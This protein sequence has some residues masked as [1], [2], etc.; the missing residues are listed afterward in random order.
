MRTN[1]LKHMRPQ[2]I[3]DAKKEKSIVYLPIGPLEWHGPALPFGVDP[4]IAELNAKIIADKVGGVV[5]PTLYCGTERERT[6]E[7]LDAMGFEDTDQYIVGQDFPGNTVK[8]LYSKEDIFANIVREYIRL[9]VMQKYKLIVI[10]NG[11]GADG[12]FATLDRLCKEFTNESDSTVMWCMSMPENF[13]PNF[14]GHANIS[15]TSMQMYICG[16]D[17]D[18]SQLPSK[19][20]KLKNCEWGINDLST[21][22][23]HPNADKTVIGDP[24]DATEEIGQRLIEE[25]IKKVIAEIESVYSKICDGFSGG[26]NG[27]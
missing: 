26:I 15:E 16:E 12:Q 9:L 11:H 7:I 25:G 10:V 13:D 17:V 21:Y 8:S 1:E 22:M 20:V 14:M 4:Q 6:P 19:D 23:L 24:R 2:E 27:K 5:M 3:L 18:L